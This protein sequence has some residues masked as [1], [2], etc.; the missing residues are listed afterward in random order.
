MPVTRT[1][2]PALPEVVASWPTDCAIYPGVCALA[3]LPATTDRLVW[4]A[5]NPDKDVASACVR[6]MGSFRSRATAAHEGSC[7]TE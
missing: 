2:S 6:P 4:V 7:A 3:T 5:V 1:P